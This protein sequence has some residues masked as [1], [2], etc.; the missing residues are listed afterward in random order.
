MAIKT[1]IVTNRM[2]RASDPDNFVAGDIHYGAQHVGTGLG[3]RLYTDAVR[4]G[5]WYA[6]KFGSLP[7]RIDVTEHVFPVYTGRP[8]VSDGYTGAR[9]T[10]LVAD[11]Y[12]TPEHLSFRASKTCSVE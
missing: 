10:F 5:Y 7:P 11:T 4:F 2:T 1:T 12:Y 8:V 3:S 6:D 9:S